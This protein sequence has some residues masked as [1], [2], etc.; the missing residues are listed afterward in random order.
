MYPYIF[1]LSLDA[2]NTFIFLQVKL[3]KF[4]FSSLIE[5]FDSKRKI[6][7]FETVTR[8]RD[9]INDVF[10]IVYFF[11]F[12]YLRT[13]IGI[14]MIRSKSSHFET[15]IFR[16]DLKSNSTLFNIMMIETI[17]LNIYEP[18]VIQSHLIYSKPVTVVRYSV[19][20]F[21]ICLQ[22]TVHANICCKSCTKPYHII[23]LHIYSIVLGHD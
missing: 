9:E 20:S 17:A 14:Q 18:S 11:L 22:S 13:Y 1:T 7:N 12:Q 4:W 10:D 21:P 2:K 5:S 19:L 16:F 23:F 15:V 3:F 6:S 8:N